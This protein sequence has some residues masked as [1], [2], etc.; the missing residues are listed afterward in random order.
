MQVSP[1]A[2]PTVPSPAG[3]IRIANFNVENLFDL[4]DDPKHEDERTTPTAK[5]YEN[6]LAKI[7]L[8]LRDTLAGADIVAL[9]EVENQT[10]LDDLL[11]QP[12]MQGL[13]YKSVLIEGND[14]RGIDNAFLYRADRVTLDSV[15]NPNIKAPKGMPNSGGQ[16]DNTLLFARE[17]LVATFSL[18]G[19]KQAA[20]GAAQI[21]LIGNH[22]KSKAG[23]DN[24]KGERRIE[25]GKFVAGLVDD[26]R[27]KTPG[28]N[29]IVIGDL[30]SLP[31]EQPLD[32]IAKHKDGTDRMFDT[33]NK[34]PEADRYTYIFD[35]NK[36]LL[37]HV[38]VTP[39]LHQK[40]TKV[41]IPHINSGGH[42]DTKDPTTPNHSSDH[43]PIITTIQL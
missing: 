26:L 20:E 38:F 5:V 28:A 18:T 34:L 10:V 31:G 12:A 36:N 25:Q 21:T 4:V 16:I 42:S 6:K 8:A 23:E 9:N 3:Q 24:N 43:D 17:P 1:V 14:L 35:G 22:F 15:S 32:E 41:E 19:A 39:E 29:V 13:G 33:P 37:D 30:N 7:S 27:A 2:K 40:V 11:A